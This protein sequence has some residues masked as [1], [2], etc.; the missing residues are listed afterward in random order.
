MKRISREGIQVFFTAFAFFFIET[1]FF[2]ILHFTHDNLE[3]TLVISYALL[4]LALGSLVTYLAFRIRAINF[5]LLIVLFILSAVLAFLNI[6]RA[7]RFVHLSPFMIFPFMMGNI[8]ITYFLRAE[9]S[10]RMYFYDLFGATCGIFFSVAAIPLLKTENSLF[11]CIAVLCVVGF[12]FTSEYGRRKLLRSA[13]SVLLVIALGTM[14]ANLRWHFLDL[15][16]FARGGGT[17]PEK[18]FSS[19][20]RRDIPLMFSRDNLVARISVYQAPADRIYETRNDDSSSMIYWTCF[21]GDSNDV[22]DTAP[23]YQFRNDPRIPFMYYENGTQYTL[24]DV[25]PKVF[26]IGTS[27][28]GIVKSIKFLVKDPS[29]ID[30]VEIN[31]AIV[32][33]MR[34]ELYELSGRAYKDVEVKTIDARAYL[35]HARERYDLITLMNTYTIHNIGYFGEPDFVH[36]RDAIDRYLEHL[37][38]GGFILF[39]ERD[40]NERCRY[41]IFKMLNNCLAALQDRGWQEPEKH[42]F[43]YNTNESKSKYRSGWYTFIVVK[44]TPL[45]DAERAYFRRWIDSRHHIEYVLEQEVAP[46]MD[47]T[48]I[49]HTQLEYLPGETVDTEYYRFME[50]N[51][52]LSFFG[53]DIR[54]TP[55]TDMQPFI[56]DVFTDR[57]DVKQLLAKMGAVCA[58]VFCLTL[59]LFYLNPREKPAVASVP[60]VLYFL[61]LGLGYFVIEIAMMKFYQSH[62]GSPTNS[63]IFVLAGLLLSSGLGS[64]FSRDYSPKRAAWSFAGIVV[65]SAYH[66][67]LGRNVLNRLGGSLWVENILIALTIAPLGFCMGIPYPFGVERVKQVFTEKRVPIFVA[68]NSLASAFGITFGLYLSIALGF[69]GTAGVG[70][71]CYAGAL[72]LFG[73]YTRRRSVVPA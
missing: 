55:T 27:A 31:P 64:Y 14:V 63:L 71:G 21:N 70:A 62:T 49:Y 17:V 19:F 41:A 5:P 11:L 12:V 39:E 24:F 34:N 56:F 53:P 46:D 57:T 10:N 26:I 15:E 43:I 3:A 8:I 60:F 4:G 68:I 45:T 59:L 44:K 58:G 18:D 40:V 1:A 52:K 29:L 54:L 50:G 36:T 33:L 72:I 32:D 25:P 20:R 22:I 30:T 69:I 9:N 28:Q 16:R 66:I 65:F 48:F 67:F 2:H 35:K 23:L 42:F 7:P 51:D 37:N 73:V 13:F 61:L 47:F 6:T 38:D